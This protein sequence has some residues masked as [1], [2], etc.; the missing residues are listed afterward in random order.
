MIAI[1]LSKNLSLKN[2][3]YN[4]E[5]GNWPIIFTFSSIFRFVN[6]NYSRAFPVINI[7]Q[8]NDLFIKSYTLQDAVTQSDPSR[9]LMYKEHDIRNDEKK[10][11]STK[12]WVE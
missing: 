4:G 11:D 7:M 5:Y 3:T 6:W 1:K 10:T 12:N 2:F 8:C 9:R